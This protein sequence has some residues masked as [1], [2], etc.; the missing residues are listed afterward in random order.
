MFEENNYERKKYEKIYL[1]KPN[2]NFVKH[3]RRM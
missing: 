2:V 3:F 1:D